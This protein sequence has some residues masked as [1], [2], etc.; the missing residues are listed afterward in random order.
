MVS[1]DALDLLELIRIA[2]RCAGALTDHL[3]HEYA[4]RLIQE[5]VASELEG[6]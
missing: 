4:N 6:C 2:Q 5:G 1:N 3:L